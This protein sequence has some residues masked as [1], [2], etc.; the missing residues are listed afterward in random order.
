MSM[1]EN[2][3]AERPNIF[4]RS[5]P[6][7]SCPRYI[8]LVLDFSKRY[9]GFCFENSYEFLRLIDALYGTQRFS[10]Y[11]QIFLMKSWI[12]YKGSH[13]PPKQTYDPTS[14]AEVRRVGPLSWLGHQVLFEGMRQKGWTLLTISM[15]ANTVNK[16]GI[17]INILGKRDNQIILVKIPLRPFFDWKLDSTRIRC[18]L[19]QDGEKMKISLKPLELWHS[20]TLLEYS[21]RLGVEVGTALKAVLR[22]GDMMAGNVQAVESPLSNIVASTSA[23]ANRDR[24]PDPAFLLG[25]FEILMHLHHTDKKLFHRVPAEGI[26][27]I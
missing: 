9:Q 18:H 27:D 26:R 6:G 4:A 25:S 16:M 13:F 10:S 15:I 1:S 14:G 17:Y 3:V 23:V 24:S 2:E 5:L 12:L 7:G 22:F 20:T 21:K 11:T 8:I 19:T